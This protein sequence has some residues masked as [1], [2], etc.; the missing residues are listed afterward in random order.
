[1]KIR[2]LFYRA[3]FEWRNFLKT[4]RIRLID[5]LISWWTWPWNI[6][7]PPYAHVEVWLPDEVDGF[8]HPWC[9]RSRFPDYAGTCYTSTMRGEAN[10]TVKRPASEVL[11]HPERWDYKEYD[12]RPRRYRAGLAWLEKQVKENKGY[13]KKAS[14]SHLTPWRFHDKDKNNCIE[15][16]YGFAVIS[17]ITPGK[18]QRLSCAR[19]QEEKQW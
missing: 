17:R 19:T 10:G 12:I 4:R 18:M 13:D 6:G 15:I 1:M 16:D 2:F 7:T 3:K 5:D 11:T 8:T 9:Y 14:L